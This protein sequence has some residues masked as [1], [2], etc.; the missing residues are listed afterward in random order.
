LPILHLASTTYRIATKP[1]A[2]RR[3]AM[4]SGGY[5]VKDGGAGRSLCVEF[6]GFSL[7]AATRC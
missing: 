2:G 4:I 7:H 1:L 3:I 5:C 6:I